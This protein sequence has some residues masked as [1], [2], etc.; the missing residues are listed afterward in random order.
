[1]T[2]RL[3]IFHPTVAPYRIEF[4]NSLHRAFDMRICLNYYNLRSQTFDYDKIAAQFAFTPLYPPGSGSVP[5]LMRWYWAQLQ[6]FRPDL[7]LTHE[8]GPSSL[9]TL[10]HRTLT[11]R[12]YKIVSMCDDSYN[13]VAE[14]NDF[15]RRHRM[16]RRWV[17][18]RVD[19]LIL[20]EPKVTQWYQAHYGRGFYFPIIQPDGAVR[21]TYARLLPQ[22]RTTAEREGL[23]GRRI[24]LFVGRLVKLKN[25]STLIE[26]FS[27]LQ[28]DDATLMI[29]GDG[30]ER[31][32]LE[33][34]AAATGADIRFTGRLEGDA[35]WLWYNL[36]DVF[37]LPSYQEAFGA[38][39][40]EAL[41][42]GCRG[43]ISEKA[44]SQ[45]LIRPGRN[46]DVF[47]PFD[48]DQLGRKLRTEL[49]ACP[50]R[51]DPATLR[52]STMLETYDE[53]MQKLT[54]HLTRLTQS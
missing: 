9:A 15:S 13:M 4:F 1:M 28:Q 41:L 16:L 47:N 3:L 51:R 18:P 49:A 53:R 21:A 48:A 11:R 22:S 33:R 10:A 6:A 36:A 42:A 17:A 38:V 52:P 43:L 14:H 8:F 26:A 29:I 19:D 5:Q 45:C 2:P 12:R 35:L 50:P 7:V 25:I 37:V 31:P 40:A 24:V 44:G 39:T 20:V 30:P 46:G 32:A 54:E 27:R 34:Q 23:M